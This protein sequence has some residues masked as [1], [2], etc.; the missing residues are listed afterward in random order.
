[1]PEIAPA[2]PATPL[3]P[4]APSAP[5]SPVSAAPAVIPD[6]VAQD[7]L[8]QLMAALK[9]L[10][11]AATPQPAAPNATPLATTAEA[12]S[13]ALPPHAPV[14]G[15]SRDKAVD[16]VLP[17]MLA[18]MGFVTVPTTVQPLM[19]PPVA[20]GGA[21]P[22]STTDVTSPSIAIQQPAA[23][24]LQQAKTTSDVLPT[25]QAGVELPKETHVPSQ[26]E[27]PTV[28]LPTPVAT[29]AAPA[30]QPVITP[31]TPVQAQQ[32]AAAATNA[33]APTQTTIVHIQPQASFHQE[34][35]SQQDE[36]QHTIASALTDSSDSASAL[37]STVTSAPVADE[38]MLAA[39]TA[40]PA[41]QQASTPA[42]QVH[43]G[44]VVSQIFH[45]ADLY[46]LPGNKGVRINLH[47]EDLGGVQ[48]TL[49]YASGGS[50]E[51]HINVDHATTGALLQAGWTQ[52]RD[53]L[54]TQGIAPERLV[55]SVTGPSGSNQ[56]DLSSNSNGSDRRDPG[57]AAFTQ[58]G[59][60]GQQR[61]DAEGNADGTSGRRGW[62]TSPD[63]LP[64]SDDT[65]R[66]A[67]VTS[68]SRIDY[69]V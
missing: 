4:T 26:V 36:R 58:G 22:V 3:L 24:A 67:S 66:V 17:E 21:T 53:A 54:T 42:A 7:F 29:Q 45:Q 68:A 8:G 46:R 62:S 19:K 16:S 10:A 65:L 60:G 23:A 61:Q 12:A 56:L 34:Q 49:R 11:G 63:A 2:A 25:P 27:A 43:P 40:T 38:T 64:T 30:A 50:L 28:Q 48:V 20:E 52:L 55:M 39:T 18:A 44:D 69:R 32:P 9:S 51:L 13:A 57:L 33:V 1:M 37:S 35:N 14:D 31:S 5:A 47:P 6:A 15:K 41:N 59:D